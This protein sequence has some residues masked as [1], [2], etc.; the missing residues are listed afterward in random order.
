MCK[1]SNTHY[2]HWAMCELAWNRETLKTVTIPLNEEDTIAAINVLKIKFVKP[3]QPVDNGTEVTL[4]S[5]GL[6][7]TY[8]S[9]L[10][11]W[12]QE[13]TNDENFSWQQRDVFN[14]KPLLDFHLENNQDIFEE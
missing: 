11:K 4:S 12:I 3:V 13:G 9:T 14:F 7:S 1:V 6:P 5:V 2:I 10:H 8:L